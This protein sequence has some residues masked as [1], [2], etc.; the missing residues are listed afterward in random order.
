[1]ASVYFLIFCPRFNPHFS[2]KKNPF[3]A[4][5][6]NRHFRNL[7]LGQIISQIALNMLSF[8]LAIRV[9]QETQ[10]NTAVSLLILMFGIPAIVFGIIAGGIVDHFDKRDILVF[11]NLARFFL[12]FVFYFASSH[13]AVLYIL[14]VFFSLITQAF[15]PAEAPSIPSLV[16]ENFLLAANSL[17]TISFYL[18]TVIG[19]IIAGPLLKLFGTP[20][21]Y[22]FMAGLMFFASIF[23]FRLPKIKVEQKKFTF[24]FLAVVNTIF[25][26]VKFI[27]KNKRIKQSLILMT[28]A[29][30]LIM[31]LS[32]LAPGFADR[33]LAIELTDSSYL[34][35]GPAAVG[36][37]SGALIV[38]AYGERFLKGTI[39]YLGMVS[40]GLILI[41]LSLS[42]QML[43][44]LI[45]AVILLFFL[46][47]FNSFITV[48]ASTILQQDTREDM[49]GHIYGV[50]TS[51]TGGVSVLPVVLSGVLADMMG[52]ARALLYIGL[53]VFITSI[54]I[55]LRRGRFNKLV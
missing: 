23:V 53:F 7:W 12:F 32:V 54:S 24:T 21:I 1:M 42:S 2:M 37:V 51:L 16:S 52:V 20:N 31:T 35:M 27:S 47:F 55:G 8:I 13:L 4:V 34:V 45:L 48:P 15:I 41:L 10:S 30:A 36:L 19:F 29:Q 11:C 22:L 14:A 43:K 28:F 38:G 49:R 9:Y 50:L 33:V 17:F 18:S 3:L 40:T 26:G 39:I 46:G 6:A 5:Y 25:D 44:S